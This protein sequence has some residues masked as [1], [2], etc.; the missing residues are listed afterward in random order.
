[1][2]ALGG[3]HWM[4]PAYFQPDLNFLKEAGKGH[5]DDWLVIVPLKRDHLSTAVML[6]EPRPPQCL[7]AEP[8]GREE[9]R[10]HR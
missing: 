10:R 5:I 2:T 4:T 6:P 7:R 9:L 1:M 3:L 8:A